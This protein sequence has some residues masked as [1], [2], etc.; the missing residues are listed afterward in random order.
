[1]VS[2]PSSMKTKLLIINKVYFKS[3]P[4]V[5]MMYL[6]YPFCLFQGLHIGRDHGAE[7]DMI[8]IMMLVSLEMSLN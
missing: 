2:H 6:H 3:F 8:K 4:A 7:S 5:V 1:M